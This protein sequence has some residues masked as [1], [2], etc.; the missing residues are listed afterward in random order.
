MNKRFICFPSGVA[1]YKMLVQEAGLFRRVKVY[2]GVN[3]LV[4]VWGRP[5]KGSM[6][7]LRF[8]SHPTDQYLTNGVVG[9]TWAMD[10]EFDS[11]ILNIKV[12]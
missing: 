7:G 10:R 12:F 1:R 2:S 3:M 11:H 8:T 6:L 9:M 5:F 4:L